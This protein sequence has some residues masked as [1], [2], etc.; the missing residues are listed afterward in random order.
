MGISPAI[1]AAGIGAAGSIGGGFLGASGAESA[2]QTAA[3]TQMSIF[4][5]TQ[6]NLAPFIQMG[7]SAFSQLAGLLGFGPGGFNKSTAANAM[8]TV[9]SM[10]GYQFQLTQGMKATDAAAAARGLNLSGG[11]FKDET[12]YAQGY[13]QN[14]WNSYINQLYQ[15]AGLGESAAA[16]Q[17]QIGAQTGAS[18]GGN[19]F[20]GGLAATGYETTGLSSALNN[21]SLGYL[22]SQ[23]GGGGYSDLQG[24]DFSNLYSPLSGPNSIDWTGGLNLSQ[25]PYI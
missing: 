13:A 19:Q 5:K 11:Q 7:G 4:D 21:A 14:A 2:A 18:I 15:G 22:L 12:Q 20:Y 1:I 10:P 6:Q 3:N 25:P 17:G 23:Q 9:S 24:N 16:G 8:N